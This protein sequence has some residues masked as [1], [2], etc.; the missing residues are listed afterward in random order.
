MQNKN[1]KKRVSS[2][3]TEHRPDLAPDVSGKHSIV[4]KVKGDICP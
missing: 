3:I 4:S 1:C 2:D